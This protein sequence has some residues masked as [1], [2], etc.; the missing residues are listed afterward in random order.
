[1]TETMTTP[2]PRLTGEDHEHHFYLYGTGQEFGPYSVQDLQVMASA[3]QLRADSLVH[4][5]GGGGWFP[6]R[7]IP[8]LF[9]DRSWLATVLISVFLGVLGVDRL[10]LGYTGVG[11]A[12]LLTLGG[13]GVWALLDT[14]LIVL[15]KVPDSHG[16]PLR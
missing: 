5:V 2:P 13:L 15:R 8:W 3:G 9:S 4:G 7:E 10:Y 14:V 6:A 1:M 11:L 12:K 16:R